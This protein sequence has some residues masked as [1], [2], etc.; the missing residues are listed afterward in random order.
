MPHTRLSLS[1]RL[2]GTTL[3]ALG[4]SQAMA[5]GATGPELAAAKARYQQ[6]T[7]LC[8]SGQSNQ[9]RQTC[10]TEARN[11]LQAARRGSLSGTDADTAS[12]AMQRCT[13]HKDALDRRACEARVHGEDT[14]A[15]GSVGGGGILRETTILVPGS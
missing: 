2:L 6:D 12:N 5:A 15:E 13:V 14:R 9:A 8:R 4:M 11:A 1:T 3:L 10:L 7:A